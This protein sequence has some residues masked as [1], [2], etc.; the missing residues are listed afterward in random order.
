MKAEPSPTSNLD[1]VAKPRRRESAC[2][3]TSPGIAPI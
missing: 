2:E 3:W 1:G